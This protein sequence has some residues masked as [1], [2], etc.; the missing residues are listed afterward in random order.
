MRGMATEITAAIKTWN[1]RVHLLFYEIVKLFDIDAM[2]L[3]C[4]HAMFVMIT[5][6]NVWLGLVDSR[7]APAAY[8]QRQHRRYIKT[9]WR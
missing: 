3:A 5:S 1:L 8:A 4:L 2:H 9:K 6:M 7:L